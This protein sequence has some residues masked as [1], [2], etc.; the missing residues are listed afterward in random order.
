MTG[1]RFNTGL[2]RSVSEKWVT[3][4]ENRLQTF[5]RIYGILH[6]LI[7]QTPWVVIRYRVVAIEIDG[8]TAFANGRFSCLILGFGTFDR[9]LCG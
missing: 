1:R 6:N 7:G 3:N 5:H 9:L 4:L 2:D 8:T